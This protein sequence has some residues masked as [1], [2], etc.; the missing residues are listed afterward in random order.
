MNSTTAII[1]HPYLFGAP[2]G[3]V[4]EDWR[5]HQH[6]D[7]AYQ[8]DG[9]ISVYCGELGGGKTLSAM[10]EMFNVWDRSGVVATNVDIIWEGCKHY[11]RH[12]RGWDYDDR[13]VMILDDKKIE[14][15]H[16][17]TPP[18]SLIV[19]DET[20]LWFNAR[21]WQKTQRELLNFMTQARKQ[22]ND[23]IFI[24]QHEDNIDKQFRRLIRFYWRFMDSSR[25]VIP[26][27]GL[28]S[29][30]PV[31]VQSCY[32]RDGR[33][34][35]YSKRMWKDKRMYATYRT[36]GTYCQTYNRKPLPVVHAKRYHPAKINLLADDTFRVAA[37]VAATG[38]AVAGF[39]L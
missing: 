32:D 20:H 36:K 4:F 9:F 29:P 21:D 6:K 14:R 31:I 13:Q 3:Q 27:L 23:V 34:L 11:G 10:G 24:T 30:F 35:L 38:A 33:T 18:G 5:Q 1:P 39:L 22:N 26:N 7:G 2:Q 28:A 25:T 15:F 17:N 19:L 8:G 16:A 37:A 12:V